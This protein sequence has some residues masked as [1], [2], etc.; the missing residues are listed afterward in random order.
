MEWERPELPLT[1]Q[2]E[3]LSLNRTSLYYQPAPPSAEELRL[4]HR[5]DEL[6]TLYPFMGSRKITAML[7]QE[8]ETVHRNTV[9][10]YMRDMGLAAIY[11]GPN[12]SKRNLQHRT[13]PYLLRGLT[14][15]RPNHVFGIDITYI[16]LKQG[17]M[18]L[19]AVLDWYSRYVV[20][21]Q[22]EQSLEIDFVLETVRRALAVHKPE[23]FNSDQGS[24]FTS[25][26]Y[27]DLLKEAGVRISMDGRGRALDNVFTE[28]LWRSV[29]YEEVYLNDYATPREARNGISRYMDFYNNVRP[30][31]SL[32]YRT[33]STV[34]FNNELSSRGD[35]IKKIVE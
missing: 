21:W 19:V 6:Y 3:L 15:Q 18:Y 13:F 11:P 35:G 32:H 20:D 7:H 4:K 5:I 17:W 2:A 26:Q 24:H 12:L 1:V 25:P 10:V 34:Y 31:Q 14:I 23:I 16:R 9:Q 8:G 22:L 29:K 27:T 33:P 28:R 30:H